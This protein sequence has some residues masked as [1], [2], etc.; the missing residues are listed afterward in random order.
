MAKKFYTSRSDSPSSVSLVCYP[1]SL[2]AGSPDAPLVA[3]IPEA[4]E[5]LSRQP[6]RALFI[7]HD[8][9]LEDDGVTLK[10]EHGHVACWFGRGIG[11]GPVADGFGIQVTQIPKYTGKLDVFKTALYFLHWDDASVD[12]G[13]HMY[14]LSE[15]C[16][17]GDWFRSGKDLRADLLNR[18]SA[19]LSGV[20]L[21]VFDMQE[22]RELLRQW[23][24]MVQDPYMCT[25][26]DF[27]DFVQANVQGLTHS[28]MLWVD[29]SAAIRE[30][31]AIR[32]HSLEVLQME[33]EEQRRKE[34]GGGQRG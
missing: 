16:F 5:G 14:D 34:S 1:D 27:E 19:V 29:R 4:L 7:D 28:R 22:I 31:I 25:V 18:L 21:G 32:R 12:A 33:R 20:D 24:P 2:P 9:D 11:I 8:Q 6:V 23:L 13:K 15:L 30:K 10:K 17:W 26:L 3:R